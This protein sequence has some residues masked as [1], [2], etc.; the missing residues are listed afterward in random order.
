MRLLIGSQCSYLM[1]SVTWSRRCQCP[2]A[3]YWRSPSCA[4]RPSACINLSKC[5]HSYSRAHHVDKKLRSSA[6]ERLTALR[7]NPMTSSRTL[8]HHLEP[9]DI[10][11]NPMTSSR[12]LWHRLEP[13]NIISTIVCEYGTL[14]RFTFAPLKGWLLQKSTE[15]IYAVLHSTNW[16]SF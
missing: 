8:W 4:S 12:T 11:S 1:R 9:Y 7:S 14:F 5:R 10:V 6:L 13:F 3:R 2:A 15:N 16:N